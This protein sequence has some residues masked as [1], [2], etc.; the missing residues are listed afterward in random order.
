MVFNYA[1]RYV[2]SVTDSQNEK[3]FADRPK[4]RYLRETN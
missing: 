1:Q 2:K 4:K 3:Y